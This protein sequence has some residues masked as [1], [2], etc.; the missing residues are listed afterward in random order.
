M[1]F[2]SYYFSLCV[3]SQGKNNLSHIADFRLECCILEGR[4]KNVTSGSNL[5]ADGSNFATA[6]DQAGHR[7]MGSLRKTG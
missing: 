1:P 5:R 2:A 7:L 4:A 3:D 6:G